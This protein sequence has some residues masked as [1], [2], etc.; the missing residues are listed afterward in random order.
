[1][2]FFSRRRILSILLAT[3]ASLPFIGTVQAADD[4]PSRPIK[5][6]IGF[7]PGGSTDAPMR[8]LAEKAADILGQPIVV[9]N[10][11]GAGGTLATLQLQNAVNDGHTLALAPIS[12]YRMPFVTNFQMD[13]LNELSYVIGLTGYAF[14][15]VVPES[16]PFQTFEELV[17][18][19]QDNPISYGTA[20]PLTSNH[21]TMEQIAEKTGMQVEHIP[22]KGA[23]ESINAV[24]GEHVDASAEASA[25]VP[26]V[27]DGK[28]RLLVVWSGERLKSF[29]DVPTLQEVGIDMVQTSPWGIVAP[30]DTDPAIVKKLHDAFKEAMESQEFIDM[31]DNYD[32]TPHYMNSQEFKEFAIESTAEQKAILERLGLM[33]NQ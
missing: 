5:I 18:Y 3:A 15:I 2:R 14:G 25:W 12:L 30:K 33:E 32:M 26:H 27:A 29:P 16:S 24:L 28:L 11:T 20:G 17:E 4:F 9:E 22:Y 7:P 8:V 31:L 6:Y 1:M 13:P 10:K 23:A 19:A 21:L